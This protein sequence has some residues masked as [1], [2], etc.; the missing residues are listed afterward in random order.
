VDGGSDG[1]IREFL[2]FSDCLVW[3]SRGGEREGPA[4]SAWTGGGGGG[5]GKGRPGGVRPMFMRSRSKSENELPI[6][7]SRS[8]SQLDLG[9]GGGGEGGEEKRWYRGRVEL[10]DLEV[11]GSVAEESMFEVLSPEGSFTLYACS[12]LLSLLSSVFTLTNITNERTKTATQESRDEWLTQIR[13]AKQTLL[14]TLQETNPN[15]TLTSSTSTN[16]VRKALQALPH[17]PSD[18][19]PRSSGGGK[20]ERERRGKVDHFVPAVWVPD[21]KS[22]GCMR[23]NATFGWRRRR[24]HCRLCG[25]VVCAS[26][27]GKVSSLTFFSEKGMVANQ[28]KF[29]RSS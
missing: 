14:L 25:R 3:L 12:Y 5:I 6:M 20:G 11:V 13:H 28:W 15:S 7:H 4:S 26:C 27:S 8:Q 21:A 1:R 22:E 2:L 19:S 10:M 24:H 18:P 23:C 9:S 29:R 16:H 17:S